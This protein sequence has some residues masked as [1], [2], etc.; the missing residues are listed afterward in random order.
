[1]ANGQ[2][3]SGIY[4]VLMMWK[5][6]VNILVEYDWMISLCSAISSSILLIRLNEKL[7]VRISFMIKQ[8]IL[9]EKILKT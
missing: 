3:H 8:H 5:R 9:N 1:M 4:F 6:F 2:A 7:L